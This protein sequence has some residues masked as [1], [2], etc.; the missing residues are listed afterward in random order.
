MLF[1][2]SCSSDDEKDTQLQNQI[3]GIWYANS[4]TLNG[5]N[6]GLPISSKLIFN[7]DFS[8]EYLYQNYNETNEDFSQFGVWEKNE[9]SLNI[10][11][12]ST[13]PLS[14]KSYMIIDDLNDNY[15][16]WWANHEKEDGI[17]RE[18]FS[19]T[20]NAYI[21]ISQFIE[22]SI[23]YKVVVEDLS[24]GD[25]IA[26]EITSF[27]TNGNDEIVEEKRSFSRLSE[28]PS[29]VVTSHENIIVNEYKLVALKIDAITEN[30]NGIEFKLLRNFDGVEI[31][32]LDLYIDNSTT[33]FYDFETGENTILEE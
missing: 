15:L 16:T 30:V 12:D 8:V 4:S 24:I 23:I 9:N 1:V 25:E 22:F 13:Q 28:Y 6:N 11:W 32:N 2:L 7:E 3:S 18:T 33:I 5:F 26:Y 20:P 31:L 10:T 27:Y 19:R 17:L 14:G 29:A 21:D